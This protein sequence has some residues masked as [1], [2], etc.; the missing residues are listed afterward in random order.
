VF[1]DMHNRDLTVFAFCEVTGKKGEVRKSSSTR[2]TNPIHEMSMTII[3]N[4]PISHLE[5]GEY[6]ASQSNKTATSDVGIAEPGPGS[7]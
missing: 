7:I 2:Y 3:T 4:D 6:S 1:D 5:Q